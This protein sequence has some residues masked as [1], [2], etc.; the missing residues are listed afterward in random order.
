MDLVHEAGCLGGEMLHS[1]LVKNRLMAVIALPQ[2]LAVGCAAG[3]WVIL[4]C[5]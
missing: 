1:E 4:A 5:M 3:V 2:R